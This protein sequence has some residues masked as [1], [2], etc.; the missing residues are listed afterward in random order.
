MGLMEERGTD[1][2]KGNIS[3]NFTS[4]SGPTNRSSWVRVL[5]LLIRHQAGEKLKRKIRNKLLKCE[6][7]KTSE[8]LPD[9]WMYKVTK[10][11]LSRSLWCSDI[12]YFTKEGYILKS[13]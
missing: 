3:S 8:F 9:H 2:Q 6:G 10:W 5:Q 1:H 12:D 11:G 4:S 13:I 7:W